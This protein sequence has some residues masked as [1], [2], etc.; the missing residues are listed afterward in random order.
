M[1]KFARES[2]DAYANRLAR[3]TLFNAF[4][5]TIRDMTGRVF[6][7]P[8]VLEND[9]PEAI[10]AYAENID[11][12]G[13]HINVFAR[14]AFF[15]ALQTGI[16]Y[17]FVDMPR[18][19]VRPDGLSPTLRDEQDAGIRPY[20][21]YI[22]VERLLGWKSE[23]IGGVHT[24]TQIRVFEIVSE[25]DGLYGEK[26]VEQVRVVEPGRWEIHRKDQRGEW[27]VVDSG[28]SSLSKI[29]LAPIYLNRTGFM[30]GEPPLL[31]LADLNVAHW[32]SQSDQRNI[33][34]VARVPILFG[35]GLGDDETIEI[36]ASSMVRNSNPDAKLTYVE[37]TG[38]AI[39]A[40]NQDL[41]N[42]EFQMQAMGLQLLVPN[43][44]QTATGEIRDDVK[45]N[46]TLGAMARALQDA[47][48]QAL[49]YM[50]EYMG[51]GTDAGGSVVVNTDFGTRG[52]GDIQYLTQAVIAGKLDDQTYLDELKRR[53]TLAD[54]VD[55][56]VVLSR[57]ADAAPELNGGKPL[58]LHTG[59]NH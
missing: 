22:P 43:P 2:D 37:H 1:P 29:T 30:T 34:T 26:D 14:D 13:R 11:L 53:G 19:V 3:T 28:T 49:G 40:G 52:T 32:Q 31:D 12:T 16:G 25:P 45:E 56:D 47:L 46:S 33:L 27:V 5:K 36:G 54:S 21:V 48:E 58:D 7:K 44:G 6:L 15:D 59:H 17:I 20:L 10:K 39:D 42:L 38:A 24:L 4:A 18:A 8:L 23:L 55:A 57:I 51:L 50:A 9:V 35:A 41:K